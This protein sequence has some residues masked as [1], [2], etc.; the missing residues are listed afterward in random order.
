VRDAFLQSMGKRF[1]RALNYS[2][3]YGNT[4]WTI[5]DSN[6]YGNMRDPKLQEWLRND[7]AA[8]RRKDWRFV[9]IHHPPFNSAKKHAEQQH[10]RWLAGLF[11][12]HN[13]DLV[14]SGHTHNY[15]RTHPLRFL[16]P[17][18]EDGLRVRGNILPD[19][20]GRNGVIYVVSG[21][22]GAGLHREFNPQPYTAKTEGEVHSL[23]VVDI[24]DQRLT[25]RQVA[26]NGREIDRFTI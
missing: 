19:T 8:A 11:Q 10:T 5:L 12:E 25:F 24:E 16:N 21:A 13:V 17:R 4:H 18:G 9:G 20:Q 2:F 1:P 26:A 14:F 6:R 3:D 23:S 22:G 15:Q 7:L